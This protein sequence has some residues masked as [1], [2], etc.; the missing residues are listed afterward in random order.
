MFGRSASAVVV[1]NGPPAAV[2]SVDPVA[3]DPVA[4]RQALK[5]RK[6][7]GDAE[8]DAQEVLF[9]AEAA[10]ET[11][12]NEALVGESGAEYVRKAAAEQ[13]AADLRR[14]RDAAKVALRRAEHRVRLAEL[15][16]RSAMAGAAP[17]AGE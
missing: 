4:V 1:V 2:A 3:V 14:V 11:R 16:W 6:E 8:C 13:S 15:G 9:A 7:A 10:Y 5:E 12:F 17:G